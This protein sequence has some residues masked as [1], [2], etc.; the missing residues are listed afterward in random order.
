MLAE[1]PVDVIFD[2][3]KSFRDFDMRDRLAKIVVPVLV[4]AG[5][6]DRLTVATA[7]EYIADHL[8]RAS[9]EILDDCGHLAMLERH[10]EID[11]LLDEFL[12]TVLGGDTTTSS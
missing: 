9:L 11:L 8:P 7:S 6:H 2:L 5:R 10:E 4:V 12:N 3:I 1:T